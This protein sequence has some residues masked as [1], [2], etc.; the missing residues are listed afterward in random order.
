MK[1]ITILFPTLFMG[2]AMFGQSAIAKKA[3]AASQGSV[4]QHVSAKIINPTHKSK[5]VAGDQSQLAAT[6]QKGKAVTVAPFWTDDFSVAAHWNLTDHVGPDAWTI[7]T[8]GPVGSYKIPNI[9]S[10]TAAN[11]FGLFDSDQLCS[12]NQDAKLTIV[13]P[14]VC[15][16]H[17]HIVLSFQEQYRRFYDSTYI[18]VSTN[19]STWVQ[20]GVNVPLN[21][22]DNCAGNPT[23]VKVDISATAGNQATVWVRFRFYSPS[24]LG[25][26]AGCGYSWMVDDIALADQ[27]ANDLAFSQTTGGNKASINFNGFGIGYYTQLP[28]AQTGVAVFD[29]Y[30]SNL[31]Y[32]IQHAAV[33][34]IDVNNGS[35][36][37]F[38]ASSVPVDL[39]VK[40]NDSLLNTYDGTPATIFVP[41]LNT[42]ATYTATFVI[43]QTETETAADL[44]NNT[45]VRTF[46]VTDTVFAHDDGTAET[47]VSPN[48]YTGGETDGIIAASYYFPANDVASSISAYIATRTKNGAGITAELYEVDTTTG[49]TT[50]T[51]IASSDLYIVDS[52]ND[53]NHWKTLSVRTPVGASAILQAK[54]TYYAAIHA[55][56]VDYNATIP[57]SVELGGDQSTYQPDAVNFVSTDIGATWGWISNQPMIRLNTV[58]STAGIKEIVQN[59][60]VKLF[61]NMPNPTNGVSV[62]N[63]ELEKNATVALSVYDIT[64]K[65]VAGQNVGEQSTGKHSIHFN[66]ENLAAGVYTYSLTVGKNT[67]STMKMVVIK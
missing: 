5:Y 67:T 66:S 57:T 1:K 58:S 4:V 13:S 46:K 17:P 43:S 64:G 52:I 60:G 55:I 53:V 36:S 24:A 32:A 12:N 29:G 14:I 25:S 48:R 18:E 47:R 3:T 28:K 59:S 62:I 11:G 19:N 35:G 7:G 39:A 9:L 30:V 54:Y 44:L 8:T 45:T 34:S 21:N 56:N 40:A 20:Y 16:G 65:K 26:S 41:T 49:S 15:T 27:P 31:G 51:L 23:T 10:T 61:Q 6:T 37:V 50:R 63:Y 33:L 22:G 2:I 38:T 42:I